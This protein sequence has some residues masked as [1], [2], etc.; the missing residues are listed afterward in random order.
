MKQIYPRV[1]MFNLLVIGWVIILHGY[2]WH[3]I[4]SKLNLSHIFADPRIIPAKIQKFYFEPVDLPAFLQHNETNIPKIL[5][6][7]WKTKDLPP[8]FL[9]W[10]LSWLRNHPHWQHHLW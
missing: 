4:Q 2:L 7:T 9:R 1:S 5:H 8:N 6:Q 10:R 3:L